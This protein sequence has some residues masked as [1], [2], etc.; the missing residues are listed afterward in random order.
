MKIMKTSQQDDDEAHILTIRSEMCQECELGS[1][2]FSFFAGPI[3]CS[4]A[5]QEICLA[6]A[7][8]IYALMKDLEVTTNNE[9]KD[10]QDNQNQDNKESSVKLNV[11]GENHDNDNR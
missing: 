7:A 11:E 5:Q 1:S 8:E 9:D 2:S 4:Q 10:N 3:T 6:I